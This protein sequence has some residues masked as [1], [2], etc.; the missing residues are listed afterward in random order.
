MRHLLT[1]S[2]ALVPLFLACASHSSDPG[3]PAPPT[4][5]TN[6][7]LVDSKTG[8]SVDVAFAS[9]HLGT[10]MCTHDES[11]DLTTKSCAAIDPDAGAPRGTGL[12]GGPCDYSHVNLTLTASGSGTATTFHVLGG[13]ILDGNTN[14]VL[15]QIT[16]NTPLS[17]DGMQYATWD[18][19]IAAGAT[20]KVQY[21]L[22]PPQWSTIDPQFM[23]QRPYKVQ[24]Q[25]GVDGATL[26]IVSDVINRDPPVST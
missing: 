23:Y 4:G 6:G 13:A 1:A 11:R 20:L 17:W 22:T 5:T 26:T 7:E 3:T 8:L 24:L 2:I 9:A 18:E 16:A 19:T 25:L 14:A 12:C 10:E 21:T 15:Q